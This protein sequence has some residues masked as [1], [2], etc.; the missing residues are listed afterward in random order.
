[1]HIVHGLIRAPGEADWGGHRV[2]LVYGETV[3]VNR[4]SEDPPE[5]LT[6]A[7]SVSAFP[8]TDGAFEM[9]TADLANIVA[10]IEIS[11]AGP[12]GAVLAGRALSVKE[13]EEDVV[14][15]AV[16]LRPRVI[17]PSD[18]P[19]LGRR[20]RL[21]G[22]VF[23]E[24]G[25]NVP[26]GL[27]VLISGVP[28]G[29][30]GLVPLIATETQ[31]SGY[32]GA[33]WAPDLLDNA[34]AQVA[35]GPPLTVRLADGR[36]PLKVILVTR[37]SDEVLAEGACDCETAPPLG[38]A[39]DDVAGN[40]Q[41]FSQDL[42]GT[43]QDLTTPNRVVEEF[44][45]NLVVRTTE[46]QIKGT[47]LAARRVVPQQVLSDLA[48]VTIPPRGDLALPPGVALSDGDQADGHAD[49]PADDPPRR[50]AP[51]VDAVTVR[52]LLR[53]P[54]A[55]TTD[56]VRLTVLNKELRH[57][58]DVVDVA[59]RT[60]AT[61][62]ALD[63]AT[64]VDWDDT[65]T[66]YQAT[67]VAHGHV[68]NFRQVWRADGYSLG[69]L[70]HSVP[71]APGQQR[72]LAVLDW[73]RREETRRAET[74]EF[75]EE[76]DAVL[77]RDRDI[78]EIA[79]SRLAEESAGGSRASQWGVAGGIGGGFI[80]NG[81]GIFGGVAGGAG[82]ASADAWQASSRTLSA[83]TLQALRDRTSQRASAVRDQ[84]STVVKTV[85]QSEGV[86]ADTEFVANFN[87]CHAITVQH[88]EVLR[89]FLVDHELADV[90]ECLFVPMPITLF[91][92]DKARRWRES[93]QRHLRDR[94]LRPA[95]DAVER[96]LDHWQGYDLPEH[97]FSEEAP[98]ELRG[99][100]R[101]SF[102]LPRPRDAADGGFQLEHWR[103]LRPLLFSDA[104]ELWTARLNGRVQ[105]E[106]DRIFRTEI[107]PQLAERLVQR[108][109]FGY[110]TRSGTEVPLPL[111]AT[112]VSRYAEGIPLYVSLRP[113]G[114]LPPIAREEIARFTIS[115]P[116]GDLP[117]DAQVIVTG[118]RVLYH[119]PHMD[120]LL[121]D[122][123]RLL[124][125]LG[126]ADR[127]V[128]PTPVTRQE[129]RNPRAQD[130]H[131]AERL[132]AHLNEHIEWYH[133]AIWANMN[134]ARRY[135][136]LDGVIAPN[137]GG[138]S[139]AGVVENRLIGISGNCLILPVAPGIH[140][141]PTLVRD[142]KRIGLRNAYAADAP[143]PL[144]V[145]VPTRG[146]YAEAVA[147]KCNSCEVPDDTRF[148]RW[149][150][151]PLPE[152]LTPIEPVST[153]S[154]AVPQEALTPS[155]LP[156]PLVS[157]QNAP[158]LPD[159]IGLQDALKILAQG[160]LFKDITGLTQTQKN[161]LAAFKG[162]LDTAQFFGQ[163]AADLA[164]QQNLGR[165]V[166]RTLSQI[167]K[168]RADGLLSPEQAQSLAVSALRSLVGQP[169]QADQPPAD[170]PAVK[171]VIDAAAQSDQ[172]QVAVRTPEETVEAAFAG[173][174]G[175][176][177]ALTPRSETRAEFVRLPIQFDDLAGG[178]TTR[179][180]LIRPPTRATAAVRGLQESLGQRQV[181]QYGKA[182]FDAGLLVPDPAAAGQFQARM[183]LR[184]TWPASGG[185]A[186]A[187]GGRLPVVVLLH[188]QHKA[189]NV[190]WK[191]TP[192]GT[193]G[194]VDIFDADRVD[195]VP[196]FQGYAYLQDVLARLGIVSVSVDTNYANVFG[197]LVETRADMAIEALH[198][199]RRFD[200]DPASRFH[201]RLD[202]DRVGLF[203][204]SRGGDAVVRAVKKNLATAGSPYKIVAVC[205]LAPTDYTGTA[206]PPTGGE[207]GRQ[208]LAAGDLDF[209]LV[210][211]GAQD[212]DVCGL[213]G[214]PDPVGTGFRHYDRARCRKALVFL[215]GCNHNRFNTT[216]PMTDPFRVP[217]EAVRSAT[218]HRMLAGEYIGGMFAW[219]LTGH[220]E[221]AL[222]FTGQR[223]NERGVPASIVWAFG[224]Q[225]SL[226]DGFE[227]AAPAG[228]TRTVGASAEVKPFGDVSIG[229][230]AIASRTAHQTRVLHADVTGGAG[231]CLELAFGAPKDLSG[232]S[233]LSIALTADFNITTKTA[234]AG[235]PLPD[236]KITLVDDAGKSATV[237]RAAFR[238]GSVPG[239]PAFHMVDVG[240]GPQNATLLHLETAGIAFSA[241]AGVDLAKVRKVIL[242]TVAGTAPHVFVDDIRV[243]KV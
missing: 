38:A 218:E 125:D 208:D 236:L 137:S 201:G 202:F 43:C 120:H 211:H 80:G 85:A 243:S 66:L 195:E 221:F 232:F 171:K 72:R 20:L 239:R 167:E 131:L 98:E 231:K 68:L 61:R 70:L 214:A 164:K 163:Q 17:K 64:P 156:Q 153:V 220:T 172:A 151:S 87:H 62:V 144:R 161:A 13:L 234:I 193:V 108:L 146:V 142:D 3:A 50:I 185:G 168:A 165:T 90:R 166:D 177:G 15:D 143:P 78:S 128:V 74:L 199:M 121:F 16:P 123:P 192:T 212:G 132:V 82:G 180:M 99:E 241:F 204:H 4:G 170:D 105:G 113:S 71:L 181:G 213:G 40:P 79:G 173:V 141:D 111:D 117:P 149:G 198:A 93:L 207:I 97:R 197:S 37:L 86:R 215:D 196:N 53:R 6:V 112:L 157:I 222:L 223:A 184:I 24:L 136:L 139:V 225:M 75:E 12:D 69:D 203:G 9:V 36:L 27:P 10:P 103:P 237:T 73:E 205:S 152:T 122:R 35:G 162:A 240:R 49:N 154:R 118:G 106:R 210:L 148:W 28:K 110:V 8:A 230:A 5:K 19:A 83:S 60:A 92:P 76:L 226:L 14:I 140:L 160:N 33:D 228:T 67:T 219:Q 238:P 119:S 95:F 44:T 77:S 169:R 107:A 178:G 88:F 217:G 31:P 18:V 155:P 94:S 186:V 101:V 47:T 229:G 84:R 100:L 46:P 56:V 130:R 91:D 191:T 58:M 102:V 188:G 216:W 242:D 147:G 227:G 30:Q 183:R 150:E 200:L 190:K 63:A 179:F 11:V 126:G 39:A 7:R 224:T 233:D 138:R 124:N 182:F 51:M 104:L 176:A 34:H 81:W 23:D 127:V 59:R 45:Y 158:E 26:A 135:M 115:Y 175:A 1:M 25:R 22:R 114:P 57:V 189:W 41:G 206:R 133:Q 48:K 235:S 65:P 89:H 187:G 32:F 129:L 209:Y 134:A 29:R 145:S 116:E 54:T 194:G 21:S 55:L 42:G 52:E 109:R 96:V 159:P 2:D 174:V